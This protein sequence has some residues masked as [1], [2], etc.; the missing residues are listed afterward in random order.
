MRAW[1]EFLATYPLWV[2]VSVVLLL[3]GAVMILVLFRPA[4]NTVDATTSALPAPFRLT[5]GDGILLDVSQGQGKWLGLT[6]WAAQSKPDVELVE[7]ADTVSAAVLILPLPHHES[8]GE[9]KVA[10]VVSWVEQGGGLL[11]LGYYAA[12]THHG[13]S[14][15]RL[16]RQWGISFND[17]LLMPA[18]VAQEETRA[19]VF[20]VD[21]RLG[22]RIEPAS[23]IDH[24]VLSDVGA[25]VM[26]SAASLDIEHASVPLELILSSPPE[27]GIWRPEGPLD[28]D[29]MRRLIEQWV[30][31]GTGSEPVLVAFRCGQGKVAICS[32]WKV[33]SLD[34]ADNGRLLTNLIQWLGS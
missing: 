7:S 28:P 26:L 16:T 23:Q 18:G 29:G 3:A 19:H 1:I 32:T 6:A 15:S 14:L 25:I 8:L 30:P 11:V 21:E 2:K 13:T 22:I 5:Q 12:E 9:D 20:S 27:T 4:K 24:P 33:A 17:N 31:E 10:S 34:Y